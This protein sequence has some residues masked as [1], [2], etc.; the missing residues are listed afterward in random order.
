MTP[1]TE[2]VTVRLL[3]LPLGL[4]REASEHQDELQREFAL[5]QN[6]LSL[7]DTAVPV[8]LLRLV[9]QLNAVFAAFSAEPQANLVA[10]LERNDTTIDL[11]YQIPPTA[12]PG[13][14]SLRAL[15]DEA[16][17]YCR[18]GDHL[19]T[20]ATRSEIVALRR[21]FL[22]EFVAQIDGVEPTPWDEWDPDTGALPHR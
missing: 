3:R 5:I 6:S 8:R 10:A 1:S 14:I 4:Y 2:V 18:H 21:W 19:L 11:Q 16:D 20:L 7:D 13:C 12:K 17:E 22:G 15:L 9:D